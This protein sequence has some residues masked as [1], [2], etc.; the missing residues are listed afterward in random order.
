MRMSV[1]GGQNFVT[2]AVFNVEE[3][4]PGVGRIP[5]P[6]CN[7]DPEAYAAQFGDLRTTLAPYGCVDCK[8][9]GW[10]YVSA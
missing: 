1:W 9:R 10:I 5:C 8:N 6:E 4:A 7:G 2:E 3:V